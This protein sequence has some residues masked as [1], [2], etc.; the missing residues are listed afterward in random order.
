MRKTTKSAFTLVELIVVITILAILGTIGFMSIKGYTAEAKNA[1]V[2]SDLGTI[3]TTINTK[4]AEGGWIMAFI[5]GSSARLATDPSLAGTGSTPG[6]NYEAGIPNYT[7][8][9]VKAAEFQAPNGQDYKI[10][11]TT[12][13]AGRMEMAG[14]VSIDGT[15]EAVVKGNYSAR[16]TANTTV[17]PAETSGKV[18]TLE[19]KDTNTF[20]TGDT[21]HITTGDADNTDIVIKRVARDGVTLTFSTSIQDATEV[22]LTAD[23]NPT[24]IWERNAQANLLDGNGDTQAWVLP[25]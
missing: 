16:T 5:T 24:L 23:E 17:T 6:T 12:T 8:L 21:V 2:T 13:A 20:K 4:M 10:G 9:G 14:V 11:A 19:S 25:Y 1:K 18:I 22:K 15:N 3:T 7:A